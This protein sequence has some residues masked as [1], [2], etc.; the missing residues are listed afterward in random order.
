M[1][2]RYDNFSP[3]TPN[4]HLEQ[5]LSLA[6]Q[7]YMRVGSLLAERFLLGY[8][9]NRYS[10]PGTTRQIET[11]EKYVRPHLQHGK[12]AYVLVDAMR[13]EMADELARSL[14]PETNLKLSAFS[15]TAPPI[16]LIVL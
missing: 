15:G 1:E 16:T 3:F 14:S 11:Y 2:L 12:V 7:Q 13:Y 5:L 10:L 9:A 8:Q 4:D 6:R